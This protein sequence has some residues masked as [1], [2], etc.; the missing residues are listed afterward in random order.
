MMKTKAF[1]NRFESSAENAPFLVWIGGKRSFE[2][3]D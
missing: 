1:E 2:K 3:G